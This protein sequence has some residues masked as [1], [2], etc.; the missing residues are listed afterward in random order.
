MSRAACQ[1]RAP[2]AGG[3]SLVEMLVAVAVF[4][5]ASALA[6]GGLRTLVQAQ[7]HARETKTELGRLQFAMG[8]FERDLTSAAR[9]SIRDGYGA[10]KPALEG[11]SQRLELTRHGLANA[12]SLPRAE[13]ER[14]AW[15]KRDEQW[16]RLR[17][18]VLDRAPGTTA[19]EDAL[20]D[21]I[22]RM[23]L[24]FLDG[25]GRWQRQWPPEQG[26]VTPLPR[27]V[28]LTLEVQGY[29]ELV[30]VL[31]LPREPMP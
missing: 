23:Q 2:A 28:R 14:V 5:L 10:W 13:L 4:A 26:L 25:Q 11:S 29:G 12:L 1:G 19:Q 15:L 8:L 20:L 22:E 18:P 21:G 6:Y 16:L 3:F 17:W 7:T 9:R 31:E 24:E 27:A 30:R